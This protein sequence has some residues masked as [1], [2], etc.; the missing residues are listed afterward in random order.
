MNRRT[1]M[2]LGVAVAAGLWLSSR[3]PKWVDDT[4]LRL[5]AKDHL[6]SGEKN[7]YVANV[8]LDYGVPVTWVEQLKSMGVPDNKLPEYTNEIIEQ[9]IT[10]GPPGDSRAD[11]LELYKA[12]VIKRALGKV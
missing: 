10:L 5:Y 2:L 4:L 1:L 12:A 7:E 9:M 3:R 6:G 11:T 8:A